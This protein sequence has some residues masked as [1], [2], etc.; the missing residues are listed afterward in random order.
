M[1]PISCARRPR[2]LLISHFLFMTCMSFFTVGSA[3]ISGIRCS[4]GTLILGGKR[5]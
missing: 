1:T 5:R 2:L 3:V 4:A